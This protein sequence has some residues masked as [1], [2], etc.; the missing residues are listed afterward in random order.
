MTE[1]QIERV[2]TKITRV[3]RELAADKKRWG[4]YYDDSAG[5]RYVVPNL[6]LKIRDFKGAMNYFRWFAKNFPDDCCYGEFLLEWSLTLFKLGKVEDAKLKVINAYFRDTRVL[7]KF[8]G[9]Q[10][11]MVD[12]TINSFERDWSDTQVLAY[13][14]KEKDWADFTVWLETSLTSEPFLRFSKEYLEIQKQL[15]AEPD[16]TK[17]SKLREMEEALSKK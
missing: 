4:G 13:S 8:L 1:K 11:T 10:V 2:R 3:K 17:R 6:Y 14:A 16:P 9:R 15:Q 7:N 5:L 12:E